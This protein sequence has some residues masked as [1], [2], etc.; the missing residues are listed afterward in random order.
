M[1]L[2]KILTATLL[3]GSIA[4]GTVGVAAATT[5]NATTKPAQEQL[6]ARAQNA[7]QRLTNL[8][9]RARNHQ[10][11]LIALRDK[12]A[13]EGNSELVARIDGRLA[14]LQERHDRVVAR[15]TELRDKGQG[16]CDVTAA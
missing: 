8:D 16:R 7:W 9:G 2:K 5:P 14:R 1:K 3:A 11:K 12:A 4:A 13:A 10:E 15:L 6:C